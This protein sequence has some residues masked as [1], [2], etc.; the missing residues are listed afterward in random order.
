MIPFGF[1][2]L[3]LGIYAW[4]NK[5]WRLVWSVA[6]TLLLSVWYFAGR[7][8]HG[9]VDDYQN[10]HASVP[11]RQVLL[12]IAYKAN[13]YLKCWGFNNP[14][15]TVHDSILLRLVGDKIF[16]LL[17]LACL[18]LGVGVLVLTLKTGLHSV[19]TK[20]NQSFFWITL[21]IFFIVG[22]LMPG[23]AAGISDP[24]GRMIEVAIWS[25][26]CAV[27]TSGVWVARAFAT[28]ALL[29][30]VSDFFLLNAVAMKPPM[31][32]TVKTPLPAHLREFAHITYA[33]R[34]YFIVAME[35]DN[36]TEHIFP[37][38]MFLERGP[39]QIKLQNN[40]G[41]QTQ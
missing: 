35:E 24:G 26:F 1:A 17:F 28:C 29:L 15:G 27:G 33:F 3:A 36:M 13:S 4:Q 34:Y 23:A 6:P 9:D 39:H 18:L 40:S 10:V 30:M 22:L 8:G 11:Y 41:L 7:F 37:T 2:V 5:K 38:A 21:G 19:R 20:D 12:F 31:M 16:V 14:A 32:G 25:G